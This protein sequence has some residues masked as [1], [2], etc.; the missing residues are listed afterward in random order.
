MAVAKQ[1]AGWVD[2]PSEE[3]MRGLY[4][5]RVERVRKQ[6]GLSEQPGSGDD[7][8]DDVGKAFHSLKDREEEYVNALVEWVNRGLERRGREERMRGHGGRWR[9][10]RGE[11]LERLKALFAKVTDAKEGKGWLVVC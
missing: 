4:R 6:Y 5:E 1:I 11:H 7:G 9:E 3:E 8:G 10:A 2:L